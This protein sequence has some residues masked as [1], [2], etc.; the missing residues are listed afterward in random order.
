MVKGS[1]ALSDKCDR[2]F[3]ELSESFGMQAEYEASKLTTSHG[4]LPNRGRSLQEKAFDTCKD[5]KEVQFHPTD[6]K[7]TTSIA[8][9]LDS[10]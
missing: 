10:A 8:T 4:V 9:N 7:K 6:P 1:F 3:H 5:S 2:D